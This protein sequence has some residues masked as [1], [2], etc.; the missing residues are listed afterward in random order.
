MTT[1][2]HRTDFTRKAERGSHERSLADAIL[3]ES[4]VGHL[5]FLDATGQPVVLPV[6]IAPDGD[7]VLFHGSTG[8][9]LFRTLA[10]GVPACLTVTLLDALVM[11]RS[12]FESSMNYRS[13]V[14]LGAAVELD[15]ADKERA[16][17]VITDHLTP[18][19]WDDLRPMTRKEVAATSVLALPL[20][21]F[22]VKVRSGGTDEPAEDL[23]WPAW[24]GQVPVVVTTG[25]PVPEPGVPASAVVP[26]PPRAL[27]GTA[28]P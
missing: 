7:R 23:A 28:G 27:R 9:R 8:S 16:L 14:I 3:A 1:P 19:R 18:G 4:L 5:G 20:V 17:R 26:A 22:S 12:A 24:A 11:A 2:P 10:S 6:A 13:L 15:G 21:E 25:V